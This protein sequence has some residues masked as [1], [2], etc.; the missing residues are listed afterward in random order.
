[1]AVC[2]VQAVLSPSKRWVEA[3]TDSIVKRLI[4][5]EGSREGGIRIANLA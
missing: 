2:S 1:M 4:R 3:L 5:T